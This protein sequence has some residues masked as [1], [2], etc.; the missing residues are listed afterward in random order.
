MTMNN[1]Y[2]ISG[3][4]SGALIDSITGELIFDADKIEALKMNR[5][6]KQKNIILFY[7]NSQGEEAIIDAEI[8]RLER[9][10]EIIQAKQESALKALEFSMK[11]AGINALDFVTM[12]AKFKKNP[13]SLVIA[14]GT[15]LSAY[16]KVEMVEKIDK[17]AIKADLKDGKKVE[18]CSLESGERLEIL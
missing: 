14:P 7:K 8:K 11:T 6:E 5:E 4:F 12:K 13:A 9:L 1:L 16:T 18:G 17:M 10:K 2:Q 15:N 3:E